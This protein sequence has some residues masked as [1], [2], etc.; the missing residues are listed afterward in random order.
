LTWALTQKNLQIDPSPKG[1]RIARIEIARENI[2]ARSD[3][4]PYFLNYLHYTTRDYVVRQESLLS[5]GEVW[6]EARAQ[7]TARNLRNLPVLAAAL[8][9]AC[10]DANPR[11]VVMLIVTKDIWSIRMNSSYSLVGSV[12]RLGEVFPSDINL[13]GLNKQLSLHLRLAQLDLA[14]FRLYD[15]FG[16]GQLFYDQRVFGSRFQLYER[17][18]FFING[19]VPCGGAQGQARDLWCPSQP[20]GS[21]QGFYAQLA[22]IYPLYSLASEWGF[23][24]EGVVDSRQ[25]RLYRQNPMNQDA[26]LGEQQGVSLRSAIFEHPDGMQRAVPRVWDALRVNGTLSFTRAYG[27]TVKHDIFWGLVGYYSSATPPENFPF[28]AQTREWTIQNI[29]PRNES[30]LYGFVAY[31]IRATEFLRLRNV[32]AFALSEDFSIGPSLYS[33]FRI[34]KDLVHLRQ[35]FF[36]AYLDASYRWHFYG[37]LLRVGVY[38][39]TRFQPLIA[40]RPD[41]GF[42]DP[43]IEQYFQAFAR[44]TSP[45]WGI[46]RIHARALVFLRRNDID[47]GLST[48]GADSGLRGYLSSVFEGQHVMRVNIEYRSLPLN[49]WTVHVGFVAFYDGGA[50][51]GGDDPA[52][53]GVSLPFLYRQSLGI[54]IRMQF[55]QFDR[56]TIRIDMGIPLSPGGGE[57]GSWF[58]LSFGQVF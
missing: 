1:K 25:Q 51:F 6:D 4:W 19:D 7:E 18:S 52:Q 58:S 20:S 15:H 48:L 57:F 11:Q 23:R 50:V 46:G 14:N 17:L 49:L 33:E 53:P 45:L 55:P 9:V 12:L 42:Q 28:D 43:W 40:E 16:I 5:V 39:F 2:I 37:N 32:N 10:R 13:L 56:E 3:P 44:Y 34:A 47:R 29:L 24:L 21:L 22:L 54:G 35:Y 38:A 30:A 41:L 8:V 36:E 31:R 26:P 27:T